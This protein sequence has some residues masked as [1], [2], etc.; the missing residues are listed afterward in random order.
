MIIIIMIIIKIMIIIIM[1]IINNKT[2]WI[3]CK[4]DMK[5]TLLNKPSL[6][7]QTIKYWK[8]EKNEKKTNKKDR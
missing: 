3:K 5:D 6:N 8:K 2:V 7:Y 4:I 1:K